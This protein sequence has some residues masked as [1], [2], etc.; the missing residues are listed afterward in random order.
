MQSTEQYFGKNGTLSKV[1]PGY[2]PRPG[3]VALAEAV[4]QAITHRRHLLAEGPTGTGKSLAYLIPAGL[5]AIE[6]GEKTVVATANITLQEQ[7][8]RKD[9]PF[10]SRTLPAKSFGGR[11]TYTLLKGTNNYACKRKMRKL[12]KTKATTPEMEKIIAQIETSLSGDKSELDF[13]PT[14]EAW[15]GIGAASD[16]CLHQKC[17]YYDACYL[18]GRLRDADI[19]VCNYHILYTDILVRTGGARLLPTYTTLVLDEAHEAAPIAQDFYGWAISLGKMEWILRKAS[20]IS[21]APLANDIRREVHELMVHLAERLKAGKTIIEGPLRGLESLIRNFDLLGLAF[22]NAADDVAPPSEDANED[23]KHGYEEEVHRRGM[24]ASICAKHKQYLKEVSV[25]YPQKGCVY[26]IGE[27]RKSNP[28]VELKCKVVDCGP[29]LRENIF[30]QHT[31]IAVSATLATSGNFNFVA[32]QF[33]LDDGDY[34]ALT[35]P[36]PFDPANVL[37]CIPKDFP[38][39]G[40]DLHRR[41]V[42]NLVEKMTRAVDGRTMT[43]FTSNASL[44]YVTVQ[45]RNRLIKDG[46]TILVQGEMQKMAIIEKFKAGEGKKMLILATASFWQG[47]D[48]PGKALSCVIIDKLPFPSPADPVVYYM[49]ERGRDSFM[50]YMIPMAVIDL[51]QGIGRLIRTETDYGAVVVADSRIATKRYGKSINSA[52]PRDCLLSDDVEDAISFIADKDKEGTDG[53]KEP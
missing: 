46:F 15:A 1:L 25:D 5:Q 4:E 30:K 17:G 21:Q 48:I 6:R 36:S 11:L 2:H 29:F 26:S 43:L 23:D 27:S 33:G 28:P 51:K 42:A 10:V 52:F 3:Q 39:P 16:E 32:N 53:R 35:A 50:G 34:S 20:E 31:V 49:H 18:R 8:I 9:L 40:D 7:L 41:E 24:F 47:V 37:V 19:I 44:S 38:E 22:A 12:S 45:L 13:A 14:E